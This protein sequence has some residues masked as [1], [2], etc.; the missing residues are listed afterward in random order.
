VRDAVESVG[1]RIRAG[2]DAIEVGD[3]LRVF[4]VLHGGLPE[5]LGQLLVPAP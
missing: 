3:D 4:G 2:H 1:D 5:W